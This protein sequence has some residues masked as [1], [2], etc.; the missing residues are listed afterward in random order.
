MPLG[1]GLCFVMAS[2]PSPQ[3]PLED[4][5]RAKAAT[6]QH[7]LE[8][9]AAADARAD[10]H[11]AQLAAA[12]ADA[13]RQADHVAALQEALAALSEQLKSR[14]FEAEA[15]EAAAHRERDAAQHASETAEDS[16]AALHAL[17][18]TKDETIALLLE[19][20]TRYEK[21]FGLNALGPP[22]AAAATLSPPPPP[23]DRSVCSRTVHAAARCV[24]LTLGGGELAH[25]G[26]VCVSLCDA[27]RARR[28]TLVPR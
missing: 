24:A 16:L 5:L 17:V 26:C 13:A 1:C 28:S 27:I 6:V 11:A 25:A 21:T 10:A 22:A 9:V 12:A 20:L 15:A 7:L 8:K 4:Q 19:R 18:R 3:L 2:P 14:T 23:A